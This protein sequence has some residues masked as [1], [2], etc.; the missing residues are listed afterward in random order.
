MLA[1]S[2]LPPASVLFR[3][4]RMRAGAGGGGMF[5][6]S[7]RRPSLS[8]AKMQMCKQDTHLLSLLAAG[9]STL[10]VGTTINNTV[11]AGFFVF[12][13]CRLYLGPQ[14]GRAETASS[15]QRIS[16]SFTL[17]LSIVSVFSPYRA[18]SLWAYIHIMII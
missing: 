6:Y 9:R 16:F 13:F 15:K 7:P 11:P 17:Q 3:E 5:C 10:Q 18:F 14:H 8:M 1:D 4:I 12:R 2:K